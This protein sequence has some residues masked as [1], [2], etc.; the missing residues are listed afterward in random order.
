MPTYSFLDRNTGLE[1]TETMS[2]SER[3]EYLKN[4]PHVDQIFTKLNI[5]SGRGLQKPSDSF[6]DIL[7]D[8]KR[9]HSRGLTRSTVN[10]F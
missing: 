1:F 7:R 6:R 10:T 8:I 2:I 5:H 9:N 3:E 4:N